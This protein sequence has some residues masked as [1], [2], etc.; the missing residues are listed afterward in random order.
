MEINS[1]AGTLY[2]RACATLHKNIDI[3]KILF[4]LSVDGAAHRR[5]TAYLLHLFND[6]INVKIRLSL[7][8]E[9]KNNVHLK[10]KTTCGVFVSVGLWAGVL[11][12]GHYV[13]V[14]VWVGPWPLEQP[15][16]QQL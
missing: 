13:G 8:E 15:L 16:Q 4:S 9:M 6:R 10:E 14:L 3:L 1:C 11:V 5:R 12:V 2:A 7:S